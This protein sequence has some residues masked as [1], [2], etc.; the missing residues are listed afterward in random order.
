MFVDQTN[1]IKQVVEVLYMSNRNRKILLGG[2]FAV[3][4]GLV[5]T[6]IL[7]Y[8]IWPRTVG[9]A[10]AWG[11]IWILEKILQEEK[12]ET[13]PSAPPY[14]VQAI[15][16][17]PMSLPRGR[18]VS[19]WRIARAKDVSYKMVKLLVEH[20]A[21]LNQPSRRVE[22]DT[23]LIS[24]L[25]W[26]MNSAAQYLIEQGA[27]VDK[28]NKY[29]ESPLMNAAVIPDVQQIDIV[30]MLLDHD[31]KSTINHVDRNGNSALHWAYFPEI[32]ELLLENG[33]DPTIRNSEG[34][35]ALENA[36]KNNRTDKAAF[37]EKYMETDE[38]NGTE[39]G[40]LSDKQGD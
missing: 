1:I 10:I 22:G 9:E 19:D 33:A 30:R 34:L 11:N 3:I 5:T 8:A 16:W 7:L 13:G 4:A 40:D 38:V 23:P 25:R 21:D 14:L 26:R 36:R 20:D 39:T 27:S 6:A 29:Q 32:V 18:S 15:W 28:F 24:A 37:L 17:A 31:A 12:L 2:L 35:T